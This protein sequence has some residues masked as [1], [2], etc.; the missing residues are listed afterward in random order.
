MRRLIAGSTILALAVSGV[1]T[2]APSA[3]AVPADRAS[4]PQPT[5]FAFKAFGYGTRVKGGEIPAGSDT[6]AWRII[7]CTNKAGL[8][9]NNF[10][11][12]VTVPGAG[13]ARGVRTRVWTTTGGGVSASNSLHTIAQLELGSPEQGKLEINAI[14]SLSRAFHDKSGFQAETETKIGSITFTAPGGEPQD[15]TLPTP[16]E[17]LEIPGLATILIGGHL[18][19]ANEVRA[20]AFADTI[21]IQIH[22]SNTRV[23]VAHSEAHINRGVKSGIFGGWASGTRAEG[24][25]DNVKSGRTPLLVMPCQGTKGKVK[26]KS[27]ASV[28]LGGQIVVGAVSTREQ[29]TQGKRKAFGFEQ[30]NI[31]RVN[32]G[33]G[34]LIIDAIMGRANVSRVGKK[35]TRNSN[36][37]SIGS[38][39]AD[40]EPQSMPDTGV[41]EIPGVARLETNIVK[42]L[43]SGIYVTALRITL[44]DGSAAVINL[45]EVKLK[46]RAS[47]NKRR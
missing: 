13:V 8:D 30:A 27:V 10:E 17:P 40:G 33:D 2:L 39:T 28:D 46:I 21:D 25:E 31:A 35:L 14:R 45:G 26:T 34:Q 29:G 36:G 38:I 44:L 42:K 32:L 1:F 43:K 41:L 47:G 4:K 24:L 11:A 37:T 18:K 22:G 19:K 7:G 16:D 12:D 6:T 23:R 9:R 15:M 3:V 20:R 5:H